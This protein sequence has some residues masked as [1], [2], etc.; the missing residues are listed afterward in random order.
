MAATK[1]K[2]LNDLFLDTLKDIYFAEK[3]ILKALPK[4]AKAATS[5]KLRAA[6]EKHLAETEG[7][8]ERLEQVFELLEKPAR[9]KTCDAIL[10]ILDE[11]KE[12]M[13]EY[14]GT[15]ALDAGLLAA[16]QA[17]EHYEISRY[18]TLKTWAGLLG[19]KDAVKLIDQTLQQE[20]T[21]DMTLS[22][23][24]ESEVNYE[25]AA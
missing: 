5:D 22:K 17:V 16:A 10:G 1:D 19:M 14:K 8:I 9:G 25:A 11:G 4:M 6:F 20:K 13:D 23:L 15:E 18:G 2:D 24:A 7:Q 21:T 12:I 3:Q